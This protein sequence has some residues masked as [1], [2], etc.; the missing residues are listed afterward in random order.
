[1]VLM[2]VPRLAQ[3]TA[4]LAVPMNPS[5]ASPDAWTLGGFWLT[6]GGVLI[7][8]ASLVLAILIFRSTNRSD[9]Q[10][11]GELLDALQAT[12]GALEQ[13]IARTGATAANLG[14]LG[15][16]VPEMQKVA[17]YL[18]DGEVAVHA[19]RRAAGKGNHPW[20]VITSRGRVIQIY[21]GGRGGGVHGSVLDD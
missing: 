17:E 10:K 7:S 21:T 1:M 15:L 20:Q 5:N 3:T 19:R 6:A 18:G 13:T 8:I 2:I 9:Q 12:Q 4:S 16:S 14:A 11:H